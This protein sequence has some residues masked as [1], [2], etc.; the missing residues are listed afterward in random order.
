VTKIIYLVIINMVTPKARA[1]HEPFVQQTGLRPDS[2]IRG[3][4]VE[5]MLMLSSS[6]RCDQIHNC[7]WYDLGHTLLC[8]LSRT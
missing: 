7:H 2:I 3:R 5:Q 1:K 4:F 8:Y 6:F